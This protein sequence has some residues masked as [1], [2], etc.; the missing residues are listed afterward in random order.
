M[1]NVA[2]ALCDKVG[3]SHL[4]HGATCKKLSENLE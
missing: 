2:V 1:L 4:P 3:K